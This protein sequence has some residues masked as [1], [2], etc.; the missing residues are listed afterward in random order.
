[1][2]RCPRGLR[3][4]FAKPSIHESGSQGSNPC[5]S[6]KGYIMHFTID[7]QY[8][9][10]VTI[11]TEHDFIKDRNNPTHDDII[12]ILKGWDKSYSISNKDHDEF[13]KLRDQLEEQGY[14]RTVRNSW[15][16]DT[17]LKQFYLNGWRFKKNHRFPCAAAL[18]NSITCARKYGW[19]S[20][21]SL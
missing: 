10:D 6:T 11:R 9:C 12:K 13:T 7:E 5:L 1:M 17:V 2:E 19:K 15:N 8:I 21:S 16:G 14:I 20:I 3:E 18:K 4:R